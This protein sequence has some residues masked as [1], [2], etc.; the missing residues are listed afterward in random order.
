MHCRPVQCDL[1][2]M[3]GFATGKDGCEMCGCKDLN[4]RE[5]PAINCLHSC[6]HGLTEDRRGCPTCACAKRLDRTRLSLLY[7]IPSKT[8]SS[9][10]GGSRRLLRFDASSGDDD[11]AENL[12]DDSD[13]DSMELETLDDWDSESESEESGVFFKGIA[14]KIHE[15]AMKI[16]KQQ[17]SKGGKGAFKTSTLGLKKVI[18]K[19]KAKGS[20]KGGKSLNQTLKKLLSKLK[21]GRS[22]KGG[23]GAFK[24]STLGLKKVISKMKAKGSRKGVKGAS[25]T[26][27]LFKH[28]LKKVIGKM[29]AG[30]LG[31]NSSRKI[32]ATRSR[33]FANKTLSGVFSSLKKIRRARRGI[34]KRTGN[35]VRSGDDD[36][37]ENL[38]DNS[39]FDSMTLETL[40][41]SDNESESEKSGGGSSPVRNVASK[42]ASTLS[43]IRARRSSRFSKGA[44]RTLRK[45]GS[46]LRKIRARRSSRFS[47]GASRTLRKVGST[48]KKIRA[49]RSSRGYSRRKTLSKSAITLSKI[50]AK[51]SSRNTGGSPAAPSSSESKPS[52]GKSEREARRKLR[53][54]ASEKRN[55][56]R[57][58]FAKYRKE[59]AE[60]KECLTSVKSK[61]IAWKKQE[62]YIRKQDRRD[63][64]RRHTVKQ[65]SLASGPLQ[66]LQKKYCPNGIFWRENC[67]D[68]KCDPRPGMVRKK[69]KP[70][71]DCKDAVP[72]GSDKSISCFRRLEKVRELE[73]KSTKSMEGYPDDVK[74][75][76]LA[77]CP[78]GRIYRKGDHACF[79]NYESKGL[80]QCKEL[81]CKD[82]VPAEVGYSTKNGERPIKCPQLRCAAVT[83]PTGIR[84]DKN[85]CATCQCNP[86]DGKPKE[87]KRLPRDNNDEVRAKFEAYAKQCNGDKECMSQVK[88][89]YYAYIKAAKPQEVK[90]VAQVAKKIA[91]KSA[92]AEVI[93][94]GAPT[95]DEMRAKFKSYAQQCNGDKACVAEVKAKYYVAINQTKEPRDNNDEV[96]A[97]FEAY[98]KQC[99]GDKECMSQVKAK[100]Y[101][102]IKAAKPQEVKPVAQV[103]QQ[104]KPVDADRLERAKLIQA[105][106]RKLEN[107]DE[108]RAKFEAYAKQCNGDKECMSQ[109]KA[110]YYAYIKAA[111]PQEVKPVAQ[112]AQQVKP[113]DADRLER[114]KLIQAEQRKLENKD[115]VRAKFMA[116]AKQCGRDNECIAKIKAKYNSYVKSA[117]EVINQE[118]SS[119]A[120]QVVKEQKVK[121]E[122]AKKA[123]DQAARDRAVD[124]YAAVIE[125]KK[126]GIA[127]GRKQM[128]ALSVPAP[129]FAM[130]KTADFADVPVPTVRVPK[131]Q[132]T[133]EKPACKNFCRYGR[134]LDRKTGCKTCK[135]SSSTMLSCPRAKCMTKCKNG[136]VLDKRGCLTCQCQSLDNG[137]ADEG[138]IGCSIPRCSRPCKYGHVKSEKGCPTC[139]CL[140][141]TKPR[142][143]C[144]PLACRMMCKGGLARDTSGCHVCKC[145]GVAGKEDVIAAQKSVRQSDRDSAKYSANFSS[146]GQL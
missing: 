20:R 88:A 77:V 124:R 31:K 15:M 143:L 113:V 16:R 93:R 33:W 6:P 89:K 51:R 107:K 130:P 67:M 126:E 44:S 18:S 30:R 137:Q 60:D 115:E 22:G 144:R 5:C 140:S 80:T 85:G 65:A 55:Q 68:C 70:R 79:C 28:T 7:G 26:K 69:C 84:K 83:C 23:K 71:L 104:V 62:Y 72:M 114:S 57:L 119:V 49:R 19:M 105:E 34:A 46:T 98:A 35:L 111:K 59:C 40:D 74:E 133:C 141:A 121:A 122:K 8:I 110:K 106:Q 61:Y 99:N 13:F 17:A 76:I 32:K 134:V 91:F 100:Y 29:K 36:F 48:L 25:K 90:P 81:K 64:L 3:Y 52:D 127:I 14:S 95:K 86:N 108:V 125:A 92:P 47:K 9:R 50:R 101:A 94:K 118:A 21:A 24:T 129:D 87:E 39:D 136:H 45:L 11:F 128:E 42:L 116:Y 75:K 138:G 146:K 97:K 38:V 12:V 120:Q 112:V 139:K 82:V 103:A 37:A 109:V 135:C 56:E 10:R 96:R 102:Y 27:F 131:P 66:K 132:Y 54:Q 58:Q 53:Q 117:K 1:F 4:A 145:A 63:R 73:A 142:E 43:K 41:D 2:C 78:M 123:Q